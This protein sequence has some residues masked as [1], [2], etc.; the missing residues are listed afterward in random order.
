M[1]EYFIR[2]PDSEEAKGP[3]NL[4]QLQSLSEAKKVKPDTL[5]YDEDKEVWVAVH[6]NADLN[7]ALFPEEKKLA[8]RKKGEEN[9]NRLNKPE[10]EN[11]KKVTIE[12]ILAAAEGDT[13]ETKNKTVKAKWKHRTIGFTSLSLTI[14]FILSAVGLAFINLDTIQTL[15]PAL[16]LASPLVVIAAI[17]AFLALCLALSVTTVYPLVRFR[18]VAGLGC[19]ALY[20]YS[21]DQMTL[22]ALFSI[23]MICAFLN[24]FIT[25]VSVFLVTG[26]GAIGGMAGFLFM[27]FIYLNPPQA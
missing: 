16:I 4:E 22:A 13:E 8:L 2:Y 23:S 9:P 1:S 12:E 26:P 19:I 6:S 25:R 10:D 17:D 20:F 15:N 3:Y 11:R 7:E 21:F 18:A 14:T 5:Y 27:Y 24:T